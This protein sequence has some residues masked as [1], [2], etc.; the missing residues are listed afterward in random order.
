M[1][2]EQVKTLID[3]LGQAELVCEHVDGPDAAVGDGPVPV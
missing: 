2:L 1:N 3:G